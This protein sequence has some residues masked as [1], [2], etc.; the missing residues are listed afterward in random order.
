MDQVN[1]S[2]SFMGSLVI[3]VE[4]VK[5]SLLFKSSSLQKVISNL[6]LKRKLETMSYKKF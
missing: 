3:I 5:T 6:K 2:K 1:I 4:H